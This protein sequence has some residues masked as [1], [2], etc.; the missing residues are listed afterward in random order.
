MS[1]VFVVMGLALV[2]FMYFGFQVGGARGRY[3]IKAPAISGNE[4]FERHFRVQ[5]NTL[6][7]MV[8]FVPSLWMFATYIDPRWAAGLGLIYIVGRFIYAHGYVTDPAK[9]SAGFGLSF[10][11]TAMLLLGG[12]VG[13]VRAS[14]MG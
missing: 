13:A 12:I 10:L 11:P 1:L 2:Q 4:V 3:G 14:L 7:L 8:I 5:Q 9:R 6:E